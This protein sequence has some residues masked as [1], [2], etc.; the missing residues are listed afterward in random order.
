[1]TS[2]RPLSV[3]DLILATSWLALLL[4]L[5][6]PLA[7]VD[8]ASLGSWLMACVPL[9]LTLPGLLRRNRRSLQWLG[10]L[11]LFYFMLGVLQAFSP[12]PLLRGIGLLLILFCAL[13]FG[14]AIVSLRHGRNR[15]PR[16]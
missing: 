12:Q 7:L 9:L 4:L 5:S 6:A 14:A 13:L 11:V 3:L 15:P 8:G 16:D 2:L 1:M 10:F